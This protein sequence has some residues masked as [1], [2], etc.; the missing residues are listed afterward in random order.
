MDLLINAGDTTLAIESKFLEPYCG[1]SYNAQKK[2]EFRAAC[3]DTRRQSIWSALPH[4]LK[5]ARRIDFSRRRGKPRY[6][7]FDAPQLLKHLLALERNKPAGSTPH[8][9]GCYCLVNL[10]YSSD[11]PEAKEYLAEARMFVEAIRPDLVTGRR[12]LRLLT[13]QE[14]FTRVQAAMPRSGSARRYLEYLRSRYF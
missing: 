1:L 9:G 12:D 5:E 14:V 2:P 10:W 3:F 7:R 4:C 8:C 6:A 11:S 13:Y